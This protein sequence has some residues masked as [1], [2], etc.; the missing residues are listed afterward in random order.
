MSVRTTEGVEQNMQVQSFRALGISAEVADALERR[1]IVTPFPIQAL[2]LPGA[3]VR[4]GVLAQAAPRAGMAGGA[5][6]ARA[7]TG[8]GKTLAFALPIA[9]RATADDGKP[10]VLVLVPTRELAAEVAGELELVCRQKRLRAAAVY[11]GAPISSQAKRA[12]DAHI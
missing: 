7:P 2:V 1:D 10:S 12:R 3:L 5:V 4:G 8:S 11:G 6:R 9:E